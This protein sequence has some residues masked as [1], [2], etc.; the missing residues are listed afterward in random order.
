MTNSAEVRLQEGY[1]V[2][3]LLSGDAESPWPG[4]LVCGPTGETAVA[5]DAITLGD[6]WPGW[7]AASSGHVLAPLDILR[8]TDGHD[9]LLPACTERLEDFLD[10]RANGSDLSVG[11]GVTVAVSLLRGFA[12]L[13]S[14][15]EPV[16]GSWWLTEAGRPVFA[17]GD[18]NGSLHDQTDA[19]LRRVSLAVPEL[20]DALPDVI[21]AMIDPRRR[22][23]ELERAES[24]VFAVAE[25]LALATTTFGPKRARDRVIADADDIGD[26]DPPRASW[27]LSLSRHL[28]ADWADLVSRTTT[29]LWRAVRTRRPGRRR[30]WLLAGGLAGAIVAGGL[31]WPSGEGGPATAGVAQPSTSAVPTSAGAEPG[32]GPTPTSSAGAPAEDDTPEPG[33]PAAADETS[34][35]VSI[36]SALLTARTDCGSDDACLETVLESSDVAF[37]AGVVDLAVNERALTL[38]D[39]FGGAAVLRAEAV[40]PG[41]EPQLV[42]IVH[43]G[44][45]WLLRDVYA[46]AEQ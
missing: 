40:A 32:S 17:T 34:D 14:S 24:M 30:P 20:T 22:A 4:A 18:A 45:R 5:V 28:D 6:A 10:R 39:E 29:G 8:R 23:R 11:E 44:E 37:P 19:L 46:I 15:A 25:P 31:L 42:V 43:A 1:R 13:Q 27:L 16:H 12:E 9:V 7:D 35:L 36:T 26:L 41:P 38:L 33:G 3:R 2:I 21:D